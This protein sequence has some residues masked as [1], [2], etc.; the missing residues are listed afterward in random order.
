MGNESP[1]TTGH[2]WS[3]V[4]RIGHFDTPE[5]APVARVTIVPRGMGE[6]NPMRILEFSDLIGYS[7]YYRWIAAFC[8]TVN[9]DRQVERYTVNFLNEDERQQYAARKMREKQEAE[10]RIKQAKAWAAFERGETG[11]SF[12]IDPDSPLGRLL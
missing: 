7:G 6:G 8:M 11:I 4:T 5:T 9:L 10:K 3:E 12:K 2:D 1:P